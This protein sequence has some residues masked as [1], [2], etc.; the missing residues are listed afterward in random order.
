[1]R[2]Y[3]SWKF[4]LS[5][6]LLVIG[7]IALRYTYFSVDHAIAPWLSF[8]TLLLLLH[9]SGDVRVLGLI[10]L[11]HCVAVFLALYGMLPTAVIAAE[12]LLYG[13]LFTIP[14]VLYRLGFVKKWW[15]RLLL[16]SLSLYCIEIGLSISPLASFGAVGYSQLSNPALVQAASLGGVSGI[17]FVIAL[18]TS[19][20]V[21][22]VVQGKWKN[23]TG[24]MLVLLLASLHIWGALRLQREVNDEEVQLATVLP[25]WDKYEMIY[26]PRK[27]SALGL[28]PGS[29]VEREKASQFFEE[30]NKALLEAVTGNS[31]SDIIVSGEEAFIVCEE[32]YSD[33][34]CRLSDFSA[35]HK[36]MLLAP[37]GI[38]LNSSD[39]PF[40]ENRSLLFSSKGELLW[41][42]QKAHPVYGPE[43]SM[44]VAGSSEAV[45][46]EKYY[47]G[48]AG[49]ICYD[50]DFPL[51]VSKTK[52]ALLM[53]PSLDWPAVQKLH[54]GMSLFRAVEN[55]CTLIRPT[56]G[57]TTLYADFRGRVLM[58]YDHFSKG[59]MVKVGT[60]PLIDV[61][62]VYERS[63]VFQAYTAF[64]IWA[65]FAIL[66]FRRLTRLH[67]GSGFP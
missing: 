1:M 57:G 48:M 10:F 22:L 61:K 54:A 50:A 15:F 67:A 28:T 60:V 18:V 5:A 16:F 63:D 14:F 3:K 2:S 34:L 45:Q 31:T 33:L 65:L 62:T 66:L 8:F 52:G 26:G 36:L 43:A 46:V 47:N 7:G 59:T 49:I 55:G 39:H 25:D 24:F 51:F 37:V 19:T 4:I 20:A 58:E 13:L 17:S 23:S 32:D 53:V 35:K 41:N 11:L 38:M 30:N 40:M 29:P 44:I 27:L 9:I 6:L 12:A 21:E 56:V 42:Y 64:F